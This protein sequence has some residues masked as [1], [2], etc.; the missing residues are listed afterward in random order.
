MKSKYRL[1]EPNSAI[2]CA[3]SFASGACFTISLIFC[4]SQAVNPVK[5]NTPIPLTIKLNIELCKKAFTITAII[6]PISAINKIPPIWVRSFFVV[7]PTIA[8]AA[9]VPAVTKK[10]WAMEVRV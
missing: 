10:V 5:I 2:F 1:S 3:D 6:K 9:N 4:A 8:I 7:L